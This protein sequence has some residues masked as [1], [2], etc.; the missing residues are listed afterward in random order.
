MGGTPEGFAMTLPFKK[1]DIAKGS[2]NLKSYF[3][4]FSDGEPS[5]AGS[6]ACTKKLVN[7]IRKQGTKVMAYFIGDRDEPSYS[8][9]NMY[10]VKDS[11]A[12]N[13]NQLLPL[14]KSLNKMF[15]ES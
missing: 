15:M 4:S 7:D 3:I 11:H 2:Q 5:F 9:T 1:G 12:I 6:D 13:V 8:F 10:G 14:T